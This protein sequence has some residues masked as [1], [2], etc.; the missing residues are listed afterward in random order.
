MKK[1]LIPSLLVAAVLGL[2]ACRPS[3]P[4][5]ETVVPAAQAVEVGATLQKIDVTPKVDILVVVDNSL[6]MA[7]HQ[8]NLANNIFIVITGIT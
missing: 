2:S 4:K 1:K 7:F 3:N 6:S 5:Y 8:Q